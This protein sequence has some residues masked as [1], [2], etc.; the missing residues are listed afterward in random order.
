MYLPKLREVKEALGSFFSKPYTTEFPQKPF[1]A[2]EE[3]RGKPRYNPE[4]C[5]GCGTCAQVCPS[6]AITV[7]DNLETRIRKLTVD[8][9]SCMNCGQ[10]EEHCITEKG[11]QLTNE[12]SFAVMDLNDPSMFESVEKEIT[13]CEVSGQFVACTDHLK[14]VRDRLGA[15]AYAHPN[16]MLFTQKQFFRLEPSEPKEIMRREDQIKQVNPKVR[17]RIVVADEF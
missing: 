14:F 1:T 3:Y 5:V 8:Y 9:A 15:Q 17:Y 7:E 10:C 13:L 6:N 12:H 2:H 4:F 16:L 11:V